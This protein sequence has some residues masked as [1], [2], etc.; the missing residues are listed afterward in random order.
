MCDHH[1]LRVQPSVAGD[2]EHVNFLSE[3]IGALFQNEDYSDITLLVENTRF[4]AHKVIL[5]ARSDYFRYWT[6]QN[7]HL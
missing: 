1:Y 2:V 3:N 7:N 5:A 4:H 6:R